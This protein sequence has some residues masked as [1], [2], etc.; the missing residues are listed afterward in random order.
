MH[1]A[2]FGKKLWSFLCLALFLGGCASEAKVGAGAAAAKNPQAAPAGHSP[3]QAYGGSQPGYPGDG[4][5]LAPAQAA[6]QPGMAPPR[7]ASAPAPPPPAPAKAAP[8]GGAGRAQAVTAESAPRSPS[9]T[10]P[11]AEPKP[12]SR[13]GLGTEFGEAR[14]SRTH[15]V[16]FVRDAGRPFAV[17]ALNYNDRRGVDAL[18]ANQAKKET[19]RSVSSA[20]GAVTIS[21]RG[22]DGNP[23]EA[24]RVGERTFVVGQA[25]QRYSI[26]LENHTAHRFE[27]LGTVDGL[28]V[29]NGKP[30][31][32]DNR[33]YILM[34]FATLEIEGF[35]TST[36]A[37]AAFRFAAVADS[38][39]AQTGTARNVGVIGLAF[40]ME[41]GD[42]LITENELRT[43]DSASPF[44]ADPRFAQPPRR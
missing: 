8:S 12:Q 34:P 11:A 5:D 25:G 10:T 41:Q 24:V 13:P 14:A 44:P 32:F 35:R 19:N 20:N 9:T 43:R 27:A 1:G 18:A 4:A 29:I 36:A 16:S 39:A 31:T 30:G 7:D 6:P 38:Y 37:V 22:T 17:A 23:L 33:G 3:Q 2:L 26:V 21:I 40:F 28:D 15:E 42:T